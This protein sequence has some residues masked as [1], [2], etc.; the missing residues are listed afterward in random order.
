V[1][2]SLYEFRD[3][4]LMMTLRNTDSGGLTAAQLASVLGIGGDVQGVAVRAS[5]MRRFGMLDYD[6]RHKTWSLSAGGER[7][8]TAK[9]LAASQD[10]LEKVPDESMVE[11][12]SHV[13]ARYR[14]GDPLMANLLR[15][16]FLFGTSPRSRVN[17]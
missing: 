2:A 10:A 17:R 5:W 13:T 11:V 12:M 14:L 8:V 7:V 4:D 9:L 3:L 1:S 15:R 16:E 6:E